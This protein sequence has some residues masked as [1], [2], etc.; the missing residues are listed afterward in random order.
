MIATMNNMKAQ[1][2]LSVL[3]REFSSVDESWDFLLFR[4]VGSKPVS[5]LESSQFNDAN[6]ELNISSTSVVS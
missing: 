5:I 2:V 6:E 1:I 4:I 3:L